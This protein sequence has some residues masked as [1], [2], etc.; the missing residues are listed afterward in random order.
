[1]NGTEIMFACGPSFGPGVMALILC[2]FGGWLLS[3]ALALVNPLLIGFLKASATFKQINFGCWALYV[4][5]GILLLLGMGNALNLDDPSSLPWTTYAL[6]MPFITI[7][8]FV[9]LLVTRRRIRRELSN[10]QIL[11]VD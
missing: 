10:T 7:S 5:P 2:L 11:S 1:M 4:V 6:A 3:G 9:F 8:H